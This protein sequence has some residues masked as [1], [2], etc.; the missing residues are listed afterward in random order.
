MKASAFKFS[1]AGIQ[2]VDE[3]SVSDDDSDTSMKTEQQRCNSS[4]HTETG[5]SNAVSLGASNLSEY[6][7]AQ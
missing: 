5:M 2:E 1:T 6:S 7:F 4:L 3:D